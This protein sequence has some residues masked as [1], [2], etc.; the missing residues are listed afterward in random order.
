MARGDVGGGGAAPFG[1]C[2]HQL[3]M[4]ADGDLPGFVGIGF[5]AEIERDPGA[6][7][8]RQFHQ[9]G[10]ASCLR[11]GQVKTR[12]RPPRRVVIRS[13]EIGLQRRVHG[14]DVARRAASGRRAGDQRLD[15]IPRVEDLLEFRPVGHEVP[16]DMDR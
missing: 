6:Q 5:G 1:H 2:G 12:V 4:L 7:I 15:Q 10:I 3:P 13:V 9:R 16:P 8:E 11:N 14:L